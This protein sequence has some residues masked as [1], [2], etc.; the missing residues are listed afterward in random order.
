MKMLIKVC[1]FVEFLHVPHSVGTQLNYFSK[2]GSYGMIDK[3]LQRRWN[4]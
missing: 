2:M 4:V 1:A 3:A